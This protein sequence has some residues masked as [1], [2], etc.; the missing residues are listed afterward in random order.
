MNYFFLVYH[1]FVFLIFGS[2]YFL[3]MNILTILWEGIDNEEKKILNMLVDSFYFTICTHT[4]L[5]F[6]DITPKSRIIR[7]VTS[8]HMICVF[9]SFVF[10]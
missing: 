10:L 9:I 5:G 6:G 2:F 3:S 4:S 7:L 1:L 8:F